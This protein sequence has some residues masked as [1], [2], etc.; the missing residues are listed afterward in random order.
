MNSMGVSLNDYIT[1]AIEE[2]V[3]RDHL[4]EK[5]KLNEEGYRGSKS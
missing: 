1:T 3:A 5:N 4:K 2:K